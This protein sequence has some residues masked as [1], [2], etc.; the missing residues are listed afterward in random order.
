MKKI[1]LYQEINGYLEKYP[2]LEIT[3]L[4]RSPDGE[5]CLIRYTVNG[6]LRMVFGCDLLVALR[7]LDAFE[8]ELAGLE[9]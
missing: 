7:K 8:E 9:I 6:E 5:G 1:D 3:H 4:I 2:R